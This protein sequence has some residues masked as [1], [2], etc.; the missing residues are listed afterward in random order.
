MPTGRPGTRGDAAA[1]CPLE[2]A[3]IVSRAHRCAASRGISMVAR[4]ELIGMIA[5]VMTLVA[6]TAYLVA[7][8][9]EAYPQATRRPRRGV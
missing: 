3:E 4:K 8:D 5:L 7:I 9:L 1:P 2:G 6:V